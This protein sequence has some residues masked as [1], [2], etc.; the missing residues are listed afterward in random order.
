MQAMNVIEMQNNRCRSIK[1]LNSQ[2]HKYVTN[3]EL[4]D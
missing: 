3:F 1:C 4:V 2:I